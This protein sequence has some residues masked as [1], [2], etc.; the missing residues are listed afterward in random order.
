MKKRYD[1][2]SGKSGAIIEDVMATPEVA[3]LPF[4]LNMRIRLCV[5]EVVENVVN[6]AYDSGSGYM[7]VETCLCA[8]VWQI[9]F[10]DAGVPFNPLDK[11]DPD[12]TLSAEDRPIGGLGIFLCKQMMDH[13][14]YHYEDGCNVLIM[15]KKIENFV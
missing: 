13:V 11:D 10:E 4:E 15:E 2:I 5:E 6:Y 3:N 1:P 12:I 9:R 8:G 7:A 14:E